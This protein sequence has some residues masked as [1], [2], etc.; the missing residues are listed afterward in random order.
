MFVLI[1]SEVQRNLRDSSY[2]ERYKELKQAEKI[3]NTQHL[4]TIKEYQ[5][6][7]SSF[8]DKIIYKRA[9]HVV[10]DDSEKFEFSRFST[11]FQSELSS[12]TIGACA[13]HKGSC[14]C[15]SL[16][17]SLGKWLWSRPQ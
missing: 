17:H 11:T 10:S 3:L 7:E 14:N 4:G 8:E 12:E 5:I 2:N 16:R 13:A 9:K 1:D 15:D 6:N